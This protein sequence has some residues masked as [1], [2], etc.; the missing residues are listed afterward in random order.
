MDIYLIQHGRAL[1]PERDPQRPLTGEGRA[2]VTKVARY[3]A[4]A[5]AE[6]IDSPI[7]E[8]HHSGKLRAQQTAEI[9]VDA[10]CPHLAPTATEGMNPNDNP[11]AT[12]TELARKHH[13]DVAIVLVGHLPHLARLAGSLLTGDAERAPIR[14]VNAG[15]LKLGSTPDG[16]AVEWYVTPACVR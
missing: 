1:S 4:T 3:L 10:L 2:E 14:F 6:L 9:F 16:W 7:S 13:L 15:V 5:G 11:D 12:H 8:V